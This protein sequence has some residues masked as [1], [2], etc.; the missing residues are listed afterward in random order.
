MKKT[1]WTIWKHSLGSFSDEQTA[2]KDDIICVV[3]TFLVGINI[4]TCIV[5]ML[6]IG[7]NW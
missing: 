7:H 6:N 1:I 5:I 3:R 2:G 4:I